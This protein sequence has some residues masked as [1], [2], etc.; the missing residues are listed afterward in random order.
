MR[1]KFNRRFE[2]E[3]LN[4][5]REIGEERNTASHF[6]LIERIREHIHLQ[7]EAM[8][9]LKL[10]AP[11]LLR[12]EVDYQMQVINSKLSGLK[13]LEHKV[14]HKEDISPTWEDD[15]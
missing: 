13:D 6:V 1:E 8:V 9:Q 3:I 15:L 12:K 11:L 5:L 7:N 14:M 4:G 2:D 10:K